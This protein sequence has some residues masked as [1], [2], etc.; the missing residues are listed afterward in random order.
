MKSRSLLLLA[1]S[2][3][4]TVAGCG[5]KDATPEASAAPSANAGSSSES[6]PSSGSTA[7]KNQPDGSAA[8]GA[9]YR[10]QPSNPSDPKYKADPRLAGGG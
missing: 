8:P 1:I 3:L 10:I 5:S 9:A 7:V 4:L 2:A 6:A